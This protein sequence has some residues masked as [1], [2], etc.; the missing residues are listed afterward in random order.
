LAVAHI[1][2]MSGD[3]VHG[4]DQAAS[5]AYRPSAKRQLPMPAV[6]AAP[7]TDAAMLK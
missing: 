5:P 7:T 1:I 2:A 6:L 4:V 3:G